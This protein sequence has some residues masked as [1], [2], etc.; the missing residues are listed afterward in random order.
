MLDV[1]LDTLLDALKL[2][3]FLF[4]AYLL[5]EFIERRSQDRSVAIIDRAG[6]AGPALGALLGV[7]P[8]C[9]FSAATANL[10]A[11]GVITRGTLIAVFLSTSDEMLPIMISEQVPFLFIVKI[12]AIK[13]VIGMLA[14][15]LIDLLLRAKPDLHIHELCEEADCGCEEGIFKPAL[16]HTAQI[17][18]FVIIV[19]FAINIAVYFIGEENLGKFI[20]NKPVIGELLS[21]LIG[22][23]PNCAASVAITELYLSGGMSVGAMLSGLLSGAGVG[24]LVLC[25]ANRHV[26]DNLK[27][28]ALLYASAVIFG[29][30]AGLLPI[31]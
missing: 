7:V 18:L 23:V 22:L 11:G 17:F 29:L 26:K 1:I 13:F 4:L 31:F 19:S 27:T 15:F 8:Q 2:L 6:K 21:A 16:K 9:G 5:M 3:P 12:L 28:I 14:G 10:Y 24:V 25:R 30:L 20:L